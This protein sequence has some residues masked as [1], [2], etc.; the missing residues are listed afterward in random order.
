MATDSRVRRRA[1]IAF[2]SGDHAVGLMAHKAPL[3][4][5]DKMK[6]EE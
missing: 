1:D 6:N 5:A 3:E 4:R 2:K